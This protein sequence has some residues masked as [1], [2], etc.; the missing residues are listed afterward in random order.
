MCL[1]VCVHR[2][3]CVVYV[4]VH[5]GCAHPC[6]VWVSLIKVFFRENA[7]EIYLNELFFLSTF[8]YE[9]KDILL[10]SFLLIK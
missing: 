1:C 6:G 5:C 7:K 4:C 2:F 10:K 9:T 3:V 8:S